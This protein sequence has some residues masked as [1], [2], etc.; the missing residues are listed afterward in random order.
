M[1]LHLQL[2]FPMQL[3]YRGDRNAPY[4]QRSHESVLRSYYR[5]SNMLAAELP[6][7]GCV[8][9]LRAAAN[10]YRDKWLSSP[11]ISAEMKEAVT[12]LANDLDALATAI[13]GGWSERYFP[14]LDNDDG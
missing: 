11:N 12:T 4:V 7:D 14:M 5:V 1:H 8:D 10:T 3:A 13:G 6:T 9:P 2:A